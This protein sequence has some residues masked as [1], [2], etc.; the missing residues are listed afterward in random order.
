[1]P[2]KNTGGYEVDPFAPAFRV[3]DIVKPSKR[4][5]EFHRC[6]ME[7]MRACGDLKM[8]KSEMEN[9]LA[10]Y[11]T[12]RYRIIDALRSPLTSDKFF[13][14]QEVDAFGVSDTSK[15]HRT[16]HAWEISLAEEFQPCQK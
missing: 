9:R 3:G 11:A 13:V 5:V 16:V 7:Q 8:P 6:V 14:V 4:S 10:A 15:E 12:L 1:M 2:D